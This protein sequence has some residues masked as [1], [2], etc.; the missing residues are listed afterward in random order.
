MPLFTN[1]SSLINQ[2]STEFHFD[3]SSFQK[4]N[5]SPD[6]I[7]TEFLSNWSS[8]N[9]SSSPP[10]KP[11]PSRTKRD[12]DH[13]VSDMKK[14]KVSDNP[15]ST[16]PSH[17]RSTSSS[18]SILPPIN[19]SNPSQNTPSHKNLNN[20]SRFSR[21]KAS[22]L[23]KPISLINKFSN[24]PIFSFQQNV[25][26]KT[27]HN[28]TP[29]PKIALIQ[30]NKLSL[31][32]S[33]TPYRIQL[34]LQTS[35]HFFILPSF[36][37]SDKSFS[38][39][40]ISFPLF[41]NSNSKL[42]LY[43]DSTP[44]HQ[45][46]SFRSNNS[47]LPSLSLST[48][49]TDKLSSIKIVKNDTSTLYVINHILSNSLSHLNTDPYVSHIGT[50]DIHFSPKKK[51]SEPR[52]LF[53]T[54]SSKKL[55]N[56]IFAKTSVSLKYSIL[57]PSCIFSCIQQPDLPNSIAKSLSTS[58]SSTIVSSKS[59]KNIN[60]KNFFDQNS[61][62]IDRIVS[63]PSLSN[64]L[65]SNISSV[66]FTLSNTDKVDTD[67]WISCSSYLDCDSLCFYNFNSSF[68]SPKLISISLSTLL[69]T[70]FL[71]SRSIFSKS[72]QL[73]LTFRYDHFACLNNNC[74]RNQ[75]TFQSYCS[76][77][78]LLSFLR[79]QDSYINESHPISTFYV[80]LNFKSRNHCNNLNSFLKSSIVNSRQTNTS[81]T[82]INKSFPSKI[83]NFKT[84]SH[85][86][87]ENSPNI[88]L[89]IIS[90]KHSKNSQ[91]DQDLVSETTVSSHYI[92]PC[93][94]FEFIGKT[95]DSPKVNSSLFDPMRYKSFDEFSDFSISDS[96]S[97]HDTSIIPIFG[98]AR[99]KFV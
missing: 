35:S 69:G 52:S 86:S 83:L 46:T 29:S 11:H 47:I 77:C 93:Y 97:I 89:P 51:T 55:K 76:N 54:P 64:I 66:F 15:P 63:N 98:T 85:S 12:G 1:L 38:K 28:S 65:I 20:S 53:F 74:S 6:T 82:I 10:L 45:N 49:T 8:F 18:N 31:L 30:I 33:P 95:I 91:L 17:S 99:H 3:K 67:C 19:F 87:N 34:I 90:P 16:Y 80:A 92:H 57:D 84:T 96:E 62:A 36:S 23:S 71:A 48:N 60:K 75:S 50:I 44:H 72:S 39:K 41:Q 78:N 68:V 70:K 14:M 26:P 61:Y 22:S 94:D 73:L 27:T 43:Y 9:A 59:S 4:L 24:L 79:S 21:F 32:N 88:S 58:P 13:L 56:S 2:N 25:Y 5:I 81:S 42:H 7:N 40:I 37:T